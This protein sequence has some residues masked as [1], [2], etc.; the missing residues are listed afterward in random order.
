MQQSV[1]HVKTSTAEERRYESENHLTKMSIRN[2]SVFYG[3]F[4][5][6]D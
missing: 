1:L 6:S 5:R 4:R 2:L 3:K